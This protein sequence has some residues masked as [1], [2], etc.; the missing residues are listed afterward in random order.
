MGG[1]RGGEHLFS[2][3]TLCFLRK[4]IGQSI[5]VGRLSVFHV[6]FS[7]IFVKL[8]SCSLAWHSALGRRAQTGQHQCQYNAITITLQCQKLVNFERL[9]VFHVYCNS[10]KYWNRQAFANSVDP[11]QLLQIVASI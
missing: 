4:W 1:T 10:P 3:K 11:D 5:S 8:V 2:L 9:S 7:H 6:I